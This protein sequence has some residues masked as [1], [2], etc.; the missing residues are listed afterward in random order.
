MVLLLRE[1]LRILVWRNSTMRQVAKRQALY[2]QVFARFGFLTKLFVRILGRVE[3]YKFCTF[4]RRIVLLCSW[5]DNKCELQL[6]PINA[7]SIIFWKVCC[8]PTNTAY[9]PRILSLYVYIGLY[10][11][12]KQFHYKPG[13][14][15]KFPGGWGSQISIQSA[16]ERCKIVSSTHRPPIL[17]GNIPGTHFC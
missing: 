13:E 5:L 9:R 2:H 10:V 14:A 15:V 7:G 4:R 3:W 12:V 6:D 17:R 8:L 16:H 1:F 11:S